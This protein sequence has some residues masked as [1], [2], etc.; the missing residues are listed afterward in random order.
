MRDTNATSDTR[1]EERI[2]LIVQRA[3]GE[4]GI[5]DFL[6]FCIVVFWTGLLLLGAVCS[7]WPVPTNRQTRSRRT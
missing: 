4:V 7:T 1:S 6:K 2:R 3:R 5:R